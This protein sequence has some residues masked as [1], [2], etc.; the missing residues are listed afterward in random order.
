MSRYRTLT[1]FLCGSAL[2]LLKFAGAAPPAAADVKTK[3]E[4]TAGGDKAGKSTGK[5]APKA[6]KNVAADDESKPDKVVK[7][8][9]EWRKIL[10]PLQFRVTRKKFTEQAGSNPM[11]HS[12]KDG[13]YHCICCGEPLFDSKAKFESGTGWPSFFQVLNE[14]AVTELE[15]TSE[16]VVR[17]EVQ[18]SRCDAHLGHVFSDG[19]QPTGLRFCMNGASLKFVDR[20]K[21]Q[22]AKEAKA[23]TSKGTSK[24][25]KKSQEKAP[26][27]ASSAS[28]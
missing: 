7:T 3:N 13:V 12:K 22:A 17:T 21:E 9:A 27:K 15:D 8:D 1:I 25:S 11:A 16:G 26:A 6:D 10:T 19:P 24:G 28:D 5:K 18:C 2:L 23:G 4:A 20:K 14:K